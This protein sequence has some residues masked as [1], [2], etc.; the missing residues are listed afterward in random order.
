MNIK[1]NYAIKE[2][3]SFQFFGF[4]FVAIIF[5]FRFIRDLG[6]RRE[7]RSSYL[8]LVASGGR[9]WLANSLAI[10]QSLQWILYKRRRAAT[11][12]RKCLREESFYRTKSTK[13]DRAKSK[14]RG[15]GRQHKI[16]QTAC[17]CQRKIKKS[18]QNNEII[19][20][21]CSF[22]SVFT[23]TFFFSLFCLYSFCESIHLLLP[24]FKGHLMDR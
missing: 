3:I 24:R 14:G 23:S 13:T 12:A 4:Y 5:L 6:G 9:E 20:K 2:K 16:L 17:L 22:T 18:L 21:P 7:E 19:P 15:S 10:S 11:A 8:S 1:L